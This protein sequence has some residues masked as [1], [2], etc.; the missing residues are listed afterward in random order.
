MNTNSALVIPAQSP[1]AANAAPLTFNDT[2]KPLIEIANPWLWVYSI[3]AILLLAVLGWLLWRHWKSRKAALSAIPPV[4]PHVHARRM[5]EAALALL[6]EPKPFSIAVS[7]AIRIYL[8]QRFDFHAPERTT[9]EFLYELQSTEL[10]TVEQ[11]QS[12]AD[13]LANCDL[14][15]FAKYEPT[16]VELRALHAAALRLVNETE[17]KWVPG[18]PQT[19]DVRVAAPV[20]K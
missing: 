14:I 6:S 19:A 17:P 7:G 1:P 20:G 8:E 5:L 15:K 11:K 13:F 18:Q 2:V 9:E 10:L 16:E 12:L 4:P 3:A